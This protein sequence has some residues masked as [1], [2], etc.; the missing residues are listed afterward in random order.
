MSRTQSSERVAVIGTGM[1]G[2]GI[3]LTLAL[4]GH[5]V[6]LFGRSADSLARALAAV[7]AG[8]QQLRDERLTTGRS[9]QAARR[10]IQ[11][12]TD[13]AAAVARAAF[14]F[15]SISEELELKQ[16]LFGDLERLAPREAIFASNTSGLPITRIAEHMT[17]PERAATAHFW[18]PAHLMP[19]VELVKGERTSEATLEKLRQVLGAAGKRTVTVRK[20]VPGQLGNRLQ[21]ALLREAFH[22]IQEG[23]ASIE[24]VDVAVKFGPGLR[25]PA[26]GLLEHADMVGLDMVQAID[27]YLFPALS[28]AE[29]P[30]AFLRELVARGNLGA[31]TGHGLYDWTQRNAADVLA[32][33]DRFIAARLR[34]ARHVP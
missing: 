17:N 28:S 11:G 26:Y 32:A 14:V 16:Q 33:R 34:D 6:T 22:I 23:V 24:D 8:L 10:R 2:P 29:A 9:A 3:A 13:L 1:M 19:L 30:P 21:H 4:V 18:N 31:K 12:T 25:F 20:D 7:D 5:P 15:E 27:G